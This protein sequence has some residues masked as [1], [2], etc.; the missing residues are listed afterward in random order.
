MHRPIFWM[1]WKMVKNDQVGLGPRVTHL[2]GIFF[3]N[4]IFN[5]HG[6]VL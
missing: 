5:S 3:V 2:V 4:I 6:T 1:T